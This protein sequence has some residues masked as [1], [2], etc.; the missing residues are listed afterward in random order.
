MG[1][2]H[3]AHVRHLT[4]IVK[5]LVAL[6]TCIRQILITHILALHAGLQSTIVESKYIIEDHIW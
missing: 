4:I 3:H 1:I 6:E 5:C 2:K